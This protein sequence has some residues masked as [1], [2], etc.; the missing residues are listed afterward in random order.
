LAEGGLPDPET[1]LRWAYLE[2]AT[3]Y[4]YD[5]REPGHRVWELRLV[6]VLR[7]TPTGHDLLDELLRE[8]PRRR[9]EEHGQAMGWW[10]ATLPS[11]R[12]A[13]AV[14]YLPHLG[15]HGVYA[16]CVRGL[17]DADGPAG[18]A[19]AVVLA[20]FV[21]G[22]NPEAVSLLVRMA[23]RG[24]LPAETVGRQLALLL[25]RTHVAPRP[26]VALLAEAARQGAHAEVWRMLTNLLPELLPG[27]DER[28]SI[29]HV[30]AMTLAADA[31]AW[32]GARGPIPEVTTFAA[33]PGHNRFTRACVRLRDQLAG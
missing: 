24:G 23:A 28:P 9:W 12:E 6:P 27:P 2:G 25:R 16:A 7:A 19:T 1:G 13:V 21:A 29:V 30:E 26:V 17:I 15:H 10:P 14:N 18:D 5:E 4:F 22:R 3:D 31:A 32:A 8:P 33:R 20:H 11:H